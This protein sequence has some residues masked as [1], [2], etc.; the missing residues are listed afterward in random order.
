MRSHDLPGAEDGA[1]TVSFL[2]KIRA[3]LNNEQPL[4]SPMRS[5]LHYPPYSECS[6][7]REDF[8]DQRVAREVG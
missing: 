7:A 6:R 4:D 5:C 1:D 3:A 2:C 8:C